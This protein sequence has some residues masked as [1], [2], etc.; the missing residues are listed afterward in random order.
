M[1]KEKKNEVEKIE[2]LGKKVKKFNSVMSGNKA[3]IISISICIL[4]AISF[5]YSFISSDDRKN[6]SSPSITKNQEYKTKEDE[7]VMFLIQEQ[8]NIK[9]SNFSEIDNILYRNDLSLEEKEDFLKDMKEINDSSNRNYNRS[10]KKYD[11]VSMDAAEDLKSMDKIN[12]LSLKY[13]DDAIEYVKS[14]KSKDESLKYREIF[15]T[16]AVIRDTFSKMNYT[17]YNDETRRINHIKDGAPPEGKPKKS[18]ENPD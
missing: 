12:T 6:S 11:E 7:R 4:L 17:N 14:L 18:L 5:F 3:S 13:T 15:Q 16:S 10:I 9:L 1:A 8:T 2:D